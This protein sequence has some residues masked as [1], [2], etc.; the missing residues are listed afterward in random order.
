MKVDKFYLAGNSLGGFI[1]WNYALKYPEKVKRMIM[2]DPVSYTQDMPWA[3]GLISTPVIGDMARIMT[4]K[5]MVDLN[6]KE[7]FGDDT[8]ITQ[9]V[10]DRYFELI[11]RPGNRSS[12][13][14]IAKALKKYRQDPQLSAHIKDIKVPTLLMWG[15]SDRWVPVHLVENWQR[16]LPSAEKRIYP[17]VGHIPM[18]EIP[19]QTARDADQFFR[20]G[21]VPA[22]LR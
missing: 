14:N 7:V 12:M 13:V 17:G 21:S 4:P 5:F 9:A 8:R 16:D 10:Y 2:L 19:I 15:G 22:A 1:G 3:L 11:M 20:A 18:E 6:V